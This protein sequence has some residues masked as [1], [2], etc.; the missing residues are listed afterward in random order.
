MDKLKQIPEAMKDFL[1]NNSVIVTTLNLE[2]QT[3]IVTRMGGGEK[4]KTCFRPLTLNPTNDNKHDR[5]FK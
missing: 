4:Y 3:D 2:T 1:F 5:G